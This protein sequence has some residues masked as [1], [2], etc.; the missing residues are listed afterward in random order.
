MKAKYDAQTDP[1][2]I[3]ENNEDCFIVQKLWNDTCL[4]CAAID[5]MGGYEGGEVAASIAKETIVDSLVNC[6]NCENILQALEAAVIEANNRIIGER[7][8]DL[9]LKSM[10]CVATVGIIDLENALL[11]MAHVGDSRL[12][13]FREG[14]L[15]KLSH[16]H[17]LVG[18]REE[19]GELTEE[20]AMANPNRNIISRSLGEKLIN[21][22]GQ[23]YIELGIFPLYSG[24]QLLFCTDGLFDMA[25]SLDISGVLSQDIGV[26]EKNRQ[27][28]DLANE[29]G[30]N[31]NITVV[32]VELGKNPNKKI[33]K[34]KKKKGTSSP[35]YTQ[36]DDSVVSLSVSLLALLLMAALCVGFVI[37]YMF[38][39][40]F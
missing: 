36:D 35:I 38:K 21:E 1:G 14:R 30:G 5:G 17:S 16:D 22:M 37:G 32:L 10:G 24:S 3:R 34:H 4:L 2:K 26:K 19:I 25:T 23:D 7:G 31:D 40:Y 20:E 13:L 15:Q 33:K 18:Y 11:Y 12:Y 29:R 39:P 8:Q 28:I 6:Q 27:L 9:R